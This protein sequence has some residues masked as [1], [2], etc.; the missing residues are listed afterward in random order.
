MSEDTIKCTRCESD[1]PE[2]ELIELGSWWLC[3]VCYD[4]I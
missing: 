1:T 3:G 4:D 2:S